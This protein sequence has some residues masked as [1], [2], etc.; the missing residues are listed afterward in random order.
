MR[1]DDKRR[2]ARARL[3]PPPGWRNRWFDIR[4]GEH[5]FTSRDRANALDLLFQ[6]AGRT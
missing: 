2:R 6:A 4:M 5:A 3:F 1:R